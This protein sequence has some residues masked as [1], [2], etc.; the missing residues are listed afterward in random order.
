MTREILHRRTVV[1]FV[2]SR[3][4]A[5][6]WV[7]AWVIRPIASSSLS[8]RG[9]VVTVRS[10][11]IRPLDVGREQRKVI[12]ARLS[13]GCYGN[14]A[15]V[16]GISATSDKSF[17]DAIAVGIARADETLRKIRAGWVKEPGVRVVDG[18]VAECQGQ[19]ACYLRAR[20]VIGSRRTSRR[21]RAVC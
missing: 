4:V 17:E 1:A 18:K 16:T 9:D 7:R 14:V 5:R 15:R 11:A 3:L 10:C 19:H 2:E 20:R 21:R 8:G 12:G 6:T 13:G